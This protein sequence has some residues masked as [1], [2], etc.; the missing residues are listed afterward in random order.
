M[1][2][3]IKKWFYN[4]FI[5]KELRHHYV[6]RKVMNIKNANDIAIIFDATN[7]DQ[8]AVVNQFADSLKGM[9]KKI[10]L[11]GYYDIPKPAINFNF[12]YFNKENLNWHLV[13]QGILVDEFI[14]RK[15]DILINASVEESLPLEYISAFSNALYRVGLYNP[16]KLFCYDLMIDMK[17]KNLK[18]MTEEVKYYLNVV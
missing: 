4:Y 5:K 14:Q 18:K 9:K 1:I 16:A 6:E 17:E 8:T 10:H 12:P 11:F 13:P 15:F 3:K 2:R 7:T